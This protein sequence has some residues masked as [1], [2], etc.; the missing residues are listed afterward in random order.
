MARISFILVEPAVPGNIGAAARA[1]NTMGFTDLRLVNPCDHLAEEARMF[2]HGSNKILEN[3]GI[4]DSLDEA[5]GDL[6]LKVATTSKK[7]RAKVDYIPAGELNGFIDRKG[8]AISSAGIVFGNEESGLS[9][10]QVRLCDAVTTIP[11]ANPYPS[12]NLGQAVMIYAYLLSGIAKERI[13]EIRRKEDNG[14]GFHAMMKQARQVLFA[15]ELNDNPAIYHRL[16]ERMALLD[17]DDIQLVHSV[18]KRLSSF[19]GEG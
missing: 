19:G 9:N 16:L 17:E 5:T 6:D 14:Q 18:L 11:L 12:L 3:A 7:R 4:F 15:L 13:P 10:A 1:I 2:A 8:S